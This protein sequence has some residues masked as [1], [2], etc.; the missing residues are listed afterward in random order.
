MTPEMD[1]ITFVICL[2]AHETYLVREEEL[3]KDRQMSNAAAALL[4][5]QPS[6]GLR[7]WLISSIAKEYKQYVSTVRYSRNM[8]GLVSAIVM[9]STFEAYLESALEWNPLAPGPIDRSGLGPPE[10]FL[11]MLAAVKCPKDNSAYVT[12]QAAA[13]LQIALVLC[14]S[15]KYDKH[16]E[17][18]FRALSRFDS[19]IVNMEDLTGSR[20][21]L[22]VKVR[23]SGK[24][25]WIFAVLRRCQGS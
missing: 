18:L 5:P 7:C 14:L 2:Y 10:L 6:E 12:Y 24:L 8:D 4:L 9:L 16:A 15:I 25:G 19:L 11:G 17:N 3:L 1:V 13:S 21:G 22:S 23:Q 20:T